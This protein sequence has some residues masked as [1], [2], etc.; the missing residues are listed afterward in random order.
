MN[1]NIIRLALDAGLLNY[2]DNE[3]P[4]HYFL[5][6]SANEDD[7]YKLVELVVKECATIADREKDK[8]AGCGYIT[9][10]KGE[11]IKEFF[12]VE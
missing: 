8:S 12:G 1:E 10:T 3:T 6:N 11:E 4:R 7:V 5:A 9:K 2:V